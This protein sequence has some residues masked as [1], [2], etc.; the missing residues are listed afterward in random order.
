[1]RPLSLK[2]DVIK[3]RNRGG[4][5]TAVATASLPSSN[6]S[7]TR[8]ASRVT[9]SKTIES[10]RRQTGPVPVSDGSTDSTPPTSQ[11]SS[12]VNASLRSPLVIKRHRPN[13][14]I[15]GQVDDTRAHVDPTA[16]DNVPKTLT[17]Y[18]YDGS[19]SM[20]ISYD[21]GGGDSGWNWLG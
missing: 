3:K 2:T 11:L 5:G 17:G 13:D 8:L 16:A 14:S 1:M 7:N 6:A 15:P 12:P 10:V 20:N 21:D 4:T 18:R 9:A 19:A